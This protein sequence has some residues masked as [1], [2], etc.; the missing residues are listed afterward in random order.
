MQSA[1][2]P[3]GFD[4]RVGRL[5]AKAGE[6][7]TPQNHDASLVARLVRQ[8]HAAHMPE[9]KGST[10]IQ[11]VSVLMRFL[12]RCAFVAYFLLGSTFSTLFPGDP[13]ALQLWGAE[14]NR[15]TTGL[16]V[17]N[18][19]QSTDGSYVPLILSQMSA[20]A[21]FTA[22]VL[23]MTSFLFEDSVA[24]RQLAL[25]SCTIKAA[26]CYSDLLLA[27]G[28]LPIIFDAH[29][30]FVD[31]LAL[32]QINSTTLRAMGCDH[33]AH[34]SCAVQAGGCLQSRLSSIFQAHHPCKLLPKC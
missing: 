7:S 30:A 21:F 28:Q 13:A 23:N 22:M 31:A 2:Y 24:K 4:V 20:T 25:L 14:V 34:G 10:C 8:Q 18:V 26:A 16:V 32:L 27:T 9:P 3:A 19:Q 5:Q 17:F 15:A 6:Q 29:G 12:C 1:S 11:Y 33:T